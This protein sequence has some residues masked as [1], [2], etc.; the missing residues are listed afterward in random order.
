MTTRVVNGAAAA[1]RLVSLDVFRGLTMAGMVIVNNPGDWGNVYAP[2]LH[3]PW[4]GW[5][6]TDLIFPFFLFIV[7]VSITLSRKSA[8][9]AAILRRGLIILGLGLFLSGYPRFDI[10]RWRVPGVL[11]RIAIC[12]TIAALAYHASTGDRRRRGTLLFSIAFGLSIAYWLV[13]MHVPPPGGFAGDLSPEGNLGAWLDR[14]LLGGHLWRPRWDPEGLLSTVPAV[15]TTMFGTVAGL[16]LGADLTPRR[17]AWVLLVAGVAGI[18][19]GYIWNVVFPINKNL[20][21][22]SYVFFTAGAASLLLALCYWAIDIQG[23]RGWT[24]PFVILGSNAITLFMASGLLVKTLALIRVDGPEGTPIPISRYAYQQY[25]VPLASPK[26]AS[27]LYALANLAVLFGLLAW[28]Y[29]R[30]LFLKV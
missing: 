29:R 4:D 16:C 19:L 23:W 21:T 22:S 26:N 5:T 9:T 24:L 15:A 27:L 12:Y 25:F 30:R 1:T 18:V 17:K 6:P 2:L 13:M 14:A 11:Q 10:T 28:M 20:W 3:A 7:G 8:S